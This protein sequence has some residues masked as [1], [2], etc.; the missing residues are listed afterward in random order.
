MSGAAAHASPALSV[1]ADPAEGTG[2]GECGRRA[3]RPVLADREPRGRAAAASSRSTTRTGPTAP[4]W[5][6]W[7][8][9]RAASMGWHCSCCTHRGWGRAPAA[10]LQ[11]F[12]DAAFTRQRAAPPVCSRSVRRST[13]IERAL[14]TAGSRGVRPGRAG[15]PP[16]G[17]PVP[18]AGA[19][20]RAA[21]RRDRGRPRESCERVAQIAPGHDQPRDPR[22]AATPRRPRATQLAFAIAVLGRSAELRHAA[23]LA[24]LDGRRRGQRPRTRS[25][26]LPSCASARP[27]EFIHPIV[28]TTIYAE[29]PAA[30]RAADPQAGS[31]AAAVRGGAPRPRLAPHLMACGPAGDP[32]VVRRLRAAAA[33]VARS[34]CAGGRVHVPRCGRSPSRR[35]P[36]RSRQH[37]LR[38]RRGR[39][40]RSGGPE[41]DRPPARGARGRSRA[42]S[43]R[44]GRRCRCR[45]TRFRA[46]RSPRRGSRSPRRDRWMRLA[47]EGDAERLDAARRAD[48][49]RRRNSAAR[50]HGAGAS[51]ARALRGE[52]AWRHAGE[53]LVLASDCFRLRAP[54]GRGERGCPAG[55]ARAQRRQPHDDQERYNP[56]SACF[57]FATWTLVYADRARARG[58]RCSRSR[59]SPRACPRVGDR[60]R[61]SRRAAG[62]SRTLPVGSDRRG[63]GGGPRHARGGRARLGR[64]A[65]DD[66]RLRASTRWSS[67]PTPRG[68]PRVSRRTGNRRGSRLGPHG[69]PA[70]LRPRSH[71]PGDVRRSRG[72][73][74]RLR[75]DP[76]ARRCSRGWRRRRCRRAHPRRSPTTSSAT[77]S[78]RGTLAAER[79][80]GRA[81]VWGTPERAVVRPARGPGSSPAGDAGLALLRDAATAVEGSPARYERRI[82]SLTEYG[83]ALRRAGQ[84]HARPARPLRE[85]LELAEAAGAGAERAARAREELLATGARP[86]WIALQ[87]R[88]RADA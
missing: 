14:G 29:I 88:R 64:R 73:A 25:Q 46:Q 43:A 71:A 87:R 42:A 11:A 33:E 49:L 37:P 6:S 20:A 86:R 54:P 57:P 80:R 18:A 72:R 60:L 53:Q 74:A 69:Q 8:T 58:G 68:L 48:R 62:G 81:R 47:A 16:A 24:D 65:A 31:G 23:A 84:A 30:H 17:Q 26:A 32:D 15:W 19:A 44:V 52:A 3:A 4:R 78:G 9:S 5:R 27:L 38:A 76:R 10:Q 77:P 70:A 22:P 61:G 35:L 85:A 21:G 1:P 34:R 51:Q 79:A 59:S 67:A 2:V 28:R 7:T 50:P 55:G 36:G 63:G 45:E 12:A 66:D 56:H 40:V 75:A 41:A 83:A 39:A 82:R 13:S